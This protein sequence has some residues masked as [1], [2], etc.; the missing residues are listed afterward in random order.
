MR[1]VAPVRRA[2][3][4]ALALV[5]IAWALGVHR[6]LGLLVYPEQFLALTLGLALGIVFLRTDDAGRLRR[7]IDPALAALG[8]APCAVLAAQYPAR[9]EDAIYEPASALP[10]ALPILLCLIEALRR[11]AGWPLTAVILAFLAYGLLGHLAPGPFQALPIG[12][13][14]LAAQLT[15]DSSGILGLPLAIAAGVVVVFVVF[16]QLLDLSGGARF[17]TD[18]SLAL[19]GGFRGGAAKIAVLGSSLFGSI[20]GSAVSNVAT[21]GIVTIPLMTRSGLAPARAGGIEAVASTGGQLMPPVMGAS[22]F[23]MAEFLQIPYREVV[24]AALVPALLY[25]LALFVQIDLRAAR[26]GVGAVPAADRPRLGPTLR[27]G[28]AFP[29]PFAALVWGL[30]SLNLQPALAALLAIAVL[31]AAAFAVGFGSGRIGLAAV[32]AGVAR[33]GAAAA[34]IVVVTAAAG[35]VIG[36]LNETGLS[37]NLTMVLTR[38]AGESL[39]LL[40]GLAAAVSIVLGMGMPTV[41]VYVLLATLVVPGITALGVEPLPAHLFVL[42]FGMMSMITPPVAIA[43]FAAASLAG[44]TP[45]RTAWEAVRLGWSAYAIPFV[46]VASPGLL[47]IGA[48]GGVALAVAGAAVGVAGVSAALAGFAMGPARRA[49]LGAVGLALLAPWGPDGGWALLRLLALTLA[50]GTLSAPAWRAP[51]T[52]AQPRATGT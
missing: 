42:Y 40:L 19:M 35:I 48:P 26:E 27:A 4:A 47:L 29:L 2:L 10:L 6:W 51:P 13:A 21:T 33:G 7:P 28:W 22:A 44:A 24:A 38:A 49:A 39:P 14:R 20:S 23:L 3:S 34:D 5:A 25:Y 11:M 30:F 52:P 9:L 18:L 45:M 17:F 43:A 15:L 8:L 31:L 36:V 12:P 46:F 50:A 32:A 37:F 16:G 1:A 41:G